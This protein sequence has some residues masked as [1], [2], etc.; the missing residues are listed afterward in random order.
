MTKAIMIHARDNT[1]TLL[2]EAQAG[3]PVSVVRESGEVVQ[4]VTARQVIPVGHKIALKEIG[5][6]EQV[7]KYGETIG[8][9][10][11]TIQKGE[12]VHVQNVVGAVFP[13]RAIPSSR[14]TE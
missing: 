10:T 11:Q 1:A 2:G 3:E 7:L 8:V 6:G 9:A 13:G 12:H 5:E 14:K 4:E